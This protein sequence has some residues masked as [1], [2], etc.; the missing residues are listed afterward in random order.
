MISGSDERQRKTEFLHPLIHSLNSCNS[1]SWPRQKPGIQNS[2]WVF[3]TGSGD[4]NDIDS[5]RK[6]TAVNPRCVL[7]NCMAE[8]AL[9]KEERNDFSELCLPQQVLQCPFQTQS[10]A[11]K[12]N[13]AQEKDFISN[14]FSSRKPGNRGRMI[15]ICRSRAGGSE[16][17]LRLHTGTLQSTE[18]LQ[19][20]FL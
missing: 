13:P 4:M 5:E 2:V 11:E 3:P 16:S 10:A 14:S 17:F 18:S 6:M 7:R 12:M 15:L 19:K 20:S 9:Q 8:S 1:Q